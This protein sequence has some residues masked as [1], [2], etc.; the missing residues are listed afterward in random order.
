MRYQV[1]AI[2]LLATLPVAA[3]ALAQSHGYAFGTVGYGS[4]G[5]DEG[6]L[7]AGPVAGGGAG[8]D[9]TDRLALEAAFTQS[10]HERVGSLSWEGEPIAITA[11]VVYLF[12]D[13]D[14]RA[15][16]FVAGGGGY[17]RYQGTFTETRYDSPTSQPR[18]VSADWLITGHTLE[19]GTGLNLALGKIL[20]VRPEVWLTFASGSRTRP[21]PEPPYALPHAVV[22][23]GLKF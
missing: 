14:A 12:A 20:F 21:A 9:I 23:A 22:S 2:V 15:R 11:R 3:T 13:R 19:F 5:D 16:L 6:S 17:F 4:L 1:A 10:R 7:G 18:L 8:F